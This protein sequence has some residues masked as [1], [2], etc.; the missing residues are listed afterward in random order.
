MFRASL[1]PS[2]A[3]LHK[4]VIPIRPVVNNTNALA[5]NAGRIN[6]ILNNHLHLSNLYNTTSCN[7]LAIELLKLHINTHHRLLTLDIK[8]LYVNIPI[9]ETINLTKAQLAKNND[10]HTTHQ[11]MTLLSTIIKQNY[12]SI[13]YQIYQPNKGVAMG[14]PVSGTMV[15]T[16]LQHHEETNIKQLTDTKSLSFY[17]R[18]VED[19]PEGK[20]SLGRPRRRWEDN[21]EMDLQEVGGGCRDWI[22]LGQDRVK[23]RALVSTVMNFRVPKMK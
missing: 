11:M 8:D 22:E 15:E 9:Q 18:Y 13:R 3:E 1:C 10:K 6:T 14:H 21:I 23:W 12:F 7:S 16:F 19:I 4:P 17:T 5:H 20:S 2:S